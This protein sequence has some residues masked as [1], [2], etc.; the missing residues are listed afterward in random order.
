MSDVSSFG[1]DPSVASLTPAARRSL[2]EWWSSR[3]RAELDASGHF[4]LMAERLAVRGAPREIVGMAERAIDDE[5]RHAASCSK[6]ASG[7]LGE[8][9]DLPEV[10][11]PEQPSFGRASAELV[12]TLHVVLSSCISEGIASVFLRTCFVQAVPPLVRSVLKS[13]LE[14]EIEHARIGWAHLA[15]ASDGEKREVSRAVPDLLRVAKNA[16]LATETPPSRPL[17]HG[18]LSRTDLEAVVEDAIRG[19]IV[20]GFAHVGIACSMRHLQR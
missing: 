13:Q 17:G 11:E 3:A 19:L 16:W 8:P 5:L 14:D 1:A 4:R 7:Y 10:P 2:A 15:T 12:T 9:V 6:L 20:P 18:S